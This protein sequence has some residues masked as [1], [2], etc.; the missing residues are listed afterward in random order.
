[1]GNQ[2]LTHPQTKYD[3]C[4]I[5]ALAKDPVQPEQQAA[6]N[7]LASATIPTQSR[8]L[9]YVHPPP[10]YCLIFSAFLA[11]AD[12]PYYGGDAASTKFAPYEQIHPGNIDSSR[13][14]WRWRLPALQM[15]REEEDE[16]S[17]I[18]GGGEF[19]STPLVVDGV[20]YTY[21]S[22]GEQA[23]IFFGTV[24]DTLYSLDA[25]TNEPDPAFG[26]EGRVAQAVN[27]NA[28]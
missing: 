11:L 28:V 2:R 9:H 6:K 13:I 19:K 27:S 17:G 5:E 16:E 26:Q 21:W 14:V 7:E 24:P 10:A 25:R 20:L 15:D 23:R 3:G 22:D 12:W 1:M 8:S 4:L 18:G